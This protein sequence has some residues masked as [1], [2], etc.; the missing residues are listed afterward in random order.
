MLKRAKLT[1]LPNLESLARQKVGK[2]KKSINQIF[3]KKN[4]RPPVTRLGDPLPRPQPGLI[5][6]PDLSQLSINP[7]SRDFLLLGVTKFNSR[8]PLF[9]IVITGRLQ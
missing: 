6:V 3:K 2:T 9:D 4:F 5:S 7:S 8:V 1:C